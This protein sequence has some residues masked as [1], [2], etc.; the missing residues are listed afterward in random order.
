MHKLNLNKLYLFRS[1]IKYLLSFINIFCYKNKLISHQIHYK[2]TLADILDYIKNNN[3]S[4]VNIFLR[5][6]GLSKSYPIDNALRA[7]VG[8]NAR[9]QS[10]I[11]SNLSAQVWSALTVRPI[12]HT[13]GRVFGD[14][15]F[16]FL[17]I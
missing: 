13:T 17:T 11:V 5:K 15:L 3:C 1:Q 2:I 10:G 16:L 12:V 4:H 6:K 14:K 9:L 7:K 8:N